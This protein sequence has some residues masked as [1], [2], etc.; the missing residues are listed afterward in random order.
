MIYIFKALQTRLRNRQFEK[1][2]VESSVLEF[3]VLSARE[4]EAG[5]YSLG[6]DKEAF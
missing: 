4:L 2:P 6:S 5:V 1:L 3:T